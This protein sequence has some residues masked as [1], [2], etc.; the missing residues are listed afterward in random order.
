MTDKESN[1][2]TPW[3][4]DLHSMGNISSDNVRRC[5]ESG[6]VNQRRAAACCA[7]HE[8]TVLDRNAS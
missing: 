5:A 7:A 2:I 3:F 1:R 6:M 8:R 4:D